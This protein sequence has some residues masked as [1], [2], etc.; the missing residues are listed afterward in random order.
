LAWGITLMAIVYIGVQTQTTY[1]ATVHQASSAQVLVR[2]VA[3]DQYFGGQERCAL[4]DWLATVVNPPQKIFNLHTT[5]PEYQTWARQVNHD[6]LDK[7]DAINA[8]RQQVTAGHPES[9]PPE[10]KCSN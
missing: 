2:Q 1:T 9:L 10:V 8:R 6:Y 5:D 4:T 7:I 3:W